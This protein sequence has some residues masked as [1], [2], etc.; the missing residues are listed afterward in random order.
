M[1]RR[2]FL[3]L[4]GS[5]AAC[6]LMPSWAWA[7][8]LPR[9]AKI[10]RIIGFDLESKR[11]KV[12][13]KNSRLD[14][15]GDRGRD[16]MV[17]L[18]TNAGQEGIG[19][20]RASQATLATLLGKNPFDFF[21]PGEPAFRGPLG[22]GTMPLW[23]LAGKTLNQPVYQL[24]GGRGPRRVPVYDGSIYFT[25][26]LPAYADRWETRFKEE[27]DLGMRR[28]HRAFKI[29]IGRGA[30]WMPREEGYERD[31]AVVSLIRKHAGPE[32][33]LGVDA[34]NGYDLVRTKRFLTD[35]RDVNLAFIEEM[36]PE[37]VDSYLDLKAFLSR[38]KLTAL[39]ADG[40][41]QNELEPFKPFIAAH[42]IDVYE[43]DINHFGIEGIL[44][45]AAWARA[46]GL[47]VSPHG[48]G[49]LVG[50]YMSLH[51]G[52][53]IT[54]YYRAENDP[55]DND[56]LIADGY[57][58]RDGFATVPEAPGFGLKFDERKFAA[59]IKPV[60]DLAL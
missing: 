30:K 31:K 25:D 45:E 59:A 48:W 42:A 29:K 16:R 15:H 14:V 5:L 44:T 49:S 26:L 33:V 57:A 39:I 2:K 46:A 50:F 18:V 32:I 36:F 27:I 41:T 7:A 12:C 54:N 22:A 37:D 47:Q 52:R 3:T 43:G 35:L 55:L 9:D 8:D 11:P 58:I 1:T 21:V 20:C 40:E 34:N 10:T 38:Q 6:K 60:F 19:N 56:I 53:A 51:V 4:C 28:G 24:L 17:R 23:D 13:G